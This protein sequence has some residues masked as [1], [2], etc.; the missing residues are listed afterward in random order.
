MKADKVHRSRRLAPLLVLAQISSLQV[1]AAVA[2]EAYAEVGATALAGMR[3][4]FSAVIMWALVRPNLSAVAAHKWRAAAALG[5][6]FAG[7]NVAYFTAIT[8]LPIGIASTVELLGPLAVAL[9]MSRHVKDAVCA[10]AAV[11]GVVLLAAPG[12]SLPVAGLLLGGL[13]AA[14][15]ASYVLLNRK[16]GRLFD[17]WS[18]LTIAL[19][20]GACLLVP[21]AAVT[22]GAAVVRNPAVLGT[23]L[24]VA[25]LSSLIPYS[26]DMTALRRMDA[27][28]FGILLSLSPAVGAGVGFALLHEHITGQ[29]GCAIALVVAA[30][31]WSVRAAGRPERRDRRV[32]PAKPDGAVPQPRAGQTGSVE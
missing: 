21:V 1:G 12:A 8:Y 17:D 19:A 26:L 24:L 4:L 32:A 10:L 3:L 7:M 23:G 6:V 2:K 14:C 30:S 22:Q 9:A 31:A 15:R 27:R 29:Q 11:A 13:A 18:G 20:V 25:L 16:V 28:A 5:V